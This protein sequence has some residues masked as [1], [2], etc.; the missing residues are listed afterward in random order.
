MSLHTTLSQMDEL[1]WRWSLLNVYCDRTLA[2]PVPWIPTDS[3]MQWCNYADADCNVSPAQIVFSRQLRDAFAFVSRLDKFRFHKSAEALTEHSRPLPELKLG[4]RCYV[5]NQVGNYP[6]RSGKVG[7]IYGHDRYGVKIDGT[8]RLTR[9]NKKF[10]RRF[11]QASS[12]VDC[13]PVSTKMPPTSQLLHPSTLPVVLPQILPSRPCLPSSKLHANVPSENHHRSVV[14]S[15][16]WI[17]QM[18]QYRQVNHWRT[19]D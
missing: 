12:H 19:N 14:A 5:Q 15:C 10:L 4:D 6:N 1:K 3:S 13:T 17:T 7:E 16:S 8:G 2:Q 9:R 18:Y 11:T